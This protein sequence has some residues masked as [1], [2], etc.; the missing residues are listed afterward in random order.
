MQISDIDRQS[1]CEQIVRYIG[2]N[3]N[4]ASTLDS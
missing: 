1:R 3:Y 2:D 4:W